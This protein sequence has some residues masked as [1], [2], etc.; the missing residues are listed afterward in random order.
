MRNLC[1]VVIMAGLVGLAAPVAQASSCLLSGTYVLAS[2]LSFQG[3]EAQFSGTFTF[4]PPGSCTPGTA[5]T[6]DV[7]LSV[8][9]SGSTTP[10]TFAGSFAY[11]VDGT[12]AMTIG[13]DLITGAVAAV[14]GTGYA[15]ALVFVAAPTIAPP[16]IRLAGTAVRS[17][18]AGLEIGATN[19]AVGLGAFAAN[20]T[21]VANTATGGAAL[22]KNTTGN[23]NTAVGINALFFNTTGSGNIAVGHAALFGNSTG[24][25]NIGLGLG[26]GFSATTGSNNIYIGS[27]GVAAEAA[28]I[29]IGT[30]GTQQATFIAGIAGKTVTNSAA[31]LI[32]TTTGHLGT[33]V[34]SRRFKEEIRTMEDASAGLQ[35]LRPVA[36]RYK[37]PAADGSKPRQYG[38]I[39]EEVAEVY[40]EL[41]VYDAAGQPETVMYHLLPAMLLNELQ[42][43]HRQLEAQA[44]QLRAQQGQLDAQGAQ[45][46]DLKTRW[47]ALTASPQR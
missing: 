37:Q 18:L 47:E 15:N 24:S 17:S 8:L 12:G 32:D 42:R 40:P 1:T 5:G 19:T 23:S 4:T 28:T 27:D 46:A 20:T 14:E 9:F 29:H 26:A 36:F 21:G 41:V 2:A 44:A 38:L 16:T 7:S 39:A 13:Q 31:V 30:Q 10:I 22:A 6:A 45:L 35:R 25:G 33:I 43:Q 11:T 34:S 3:T